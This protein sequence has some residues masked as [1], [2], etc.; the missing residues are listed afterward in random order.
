MLPVGG[1][2]STST[3]WCSGG[4][5]VVL[6]SKVC[7]TVL[8]SRIL[9]SDQPV[10]AGVTGAV[11]ETGWSLESGVVVCGEQSRAGV[12]DASSGSVIRPRERMPV[13]PSHLG[14]TGQ[15]ITVDGRSARWCL[16][17]YLCGDVSPP[18]QMLYV[19][20]FILAFTASYLE[21]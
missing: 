7:T 8:C 12:A 17:D 15:P 21:C 13:A 16:L 9:R 18:V 10:Q 14:S 20:A 4:A 6:K 11:G 19:D 5:Q 1:G 2:S 3:S